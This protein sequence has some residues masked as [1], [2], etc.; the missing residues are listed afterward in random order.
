MFDDRGSF[1]DV[2]QL[3]GA[4]AWLAGGYGFESRLLH[5]GVLASPLAPFVQV[6]ETGD[7]FREC[8]FVE[9]ACWCQGG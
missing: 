9:A 6:L 2:A 5:H 1:G 4:P 3:G 8:H 7:A